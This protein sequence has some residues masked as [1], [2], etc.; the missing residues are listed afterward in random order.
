MGPK[1]AYGLDRSETDPT[2]KCE[3]ALWRAEISVKRASPAL[4]IG[5]LLHLFQK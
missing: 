2:R 3:Q 4:V 5:P 1:N